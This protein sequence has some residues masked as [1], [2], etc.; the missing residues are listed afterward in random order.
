MTSGPNGESELTRL[1]VT[2]STFV[3]QPERQMASKSI[4]SP[5]LMPVP[6]TV[7][8]FSFAAR[9]RSAASFGSFAA[10]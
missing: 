6:S 8:P 9:S 3:M 2:F 10:G 5:G 1:Q 7:T 4:I